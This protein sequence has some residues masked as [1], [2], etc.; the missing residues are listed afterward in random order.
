MSLR[1]NSTE[2]A[3]EGGEMMACCCSVASQGDVDVLT[4]AGK[5]S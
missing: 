4:L 1:E 3:G 2:L 5:V